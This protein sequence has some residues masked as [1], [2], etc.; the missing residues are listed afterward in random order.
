[1]RICYAQAVSP[2]IAPPGTYHTSW[3][4]NSFGGSGAT[5]V[6]PNGFGY[7]VQDGVGAMAVSPDGTVFLG[8]NW[9]E[10]GRTVGLYKN[11]RPN[12]ILVR[13]DNSQLKAWGFNTG[14]KALCVDGA[15][16]YVANSGKGLLRFQWTPGN[17]N[18]ATYL[19][20][21]LL[22]Q[23]ATGLSCSAGKI[24]VA[25][26]NQIEVRDET[27]LQPVA[28]FPVTG[29]S[30]ALLAPD[31][32]FWV[33]SDGK[34]R[35]LNAAGNDT[36]V[37]LPNIGNPT[38]LAWGQH[39]TLLVTDN[40]PAQQVLFFDVSTNPKLVSTFG[41]KG[42]LYSGIPGA[43]APQKL[44]ALRGAGMD[45][46]ANLYVAMGFSGGPNGNTYLRAF[47]PSGALLWE[48]D[49]TAFV[50][51][52]GF[53]PG[54]DGTVVYGRTTRW[55]LD[56]DH[57]QPGTEATLT[58]VTL[59]PLQFP[60]DPRIKYG[61]SVY[62][63][64]ING[65]QLLYAIG[66]KGGGFTIFTGSPGSNI[67]HQV[68]ATPKGGWAW[69]VTD[70]GDIWNG[71]APGNKIALYPLASITPAGQPVY[72]WSHPRTWP[73]PPDFQKSLGYSTART[74]TACTSS[75]ILRASQ[76]IPGVSSAFLAADTM[77]GW[78]ESQS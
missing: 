2:Y 59:D 28:S 14:N 37:T 4:G 57:Q 44:F 60:D 45:A 35:H 11:G 51:T 30:A 1:M 10:G 46:Q 52:F 50:D 77:A 27:N 64:L 8:V 66:Q 29:L 69:Q 68:A 70:A 49:A 22:P 19:N 13:A 47:S 24:L 53:L 65:T 48:D 55:Q 43:V 23:P 78:R 15:F 25:Y 9:D 56:L 32:S 72:D 5:T 74:R 33:I 75:V 67:L 36:G 71:D 61:Y 40:G 31:G 39:G 63:R 20:E 42:G 16:F 34:V 58:A 26:P 6:N 38:S 18:S 12:R 76:P 41:V 3:I 21:V 73:W 62:P 7:W 54:S 17:I